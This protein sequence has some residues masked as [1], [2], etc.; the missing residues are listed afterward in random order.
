MVKRGDVWLVHLEPTVGSENHKTRPCV[1]ISPD[2]I[3]DHQRTIIVAPMTTDSR[4]APF[5]IS[6]RHAGKVG[7]I[8]LDQIRVVDKMRL[9]KRVG[10]LSVNTMSSA[11]DAL[12]DMIEE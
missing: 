3:N 9:A 7:R 12:R 2:E 5:R 8:L 4:P 6:A 11:L 10:M 1:V